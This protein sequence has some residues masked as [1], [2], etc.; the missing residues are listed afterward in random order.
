MSILFALIVGGLVFSF[1]SA[2]LDIYRL[3]CLAPKTAYEIWL[4]EVK[5]I[6]IV[7]SRST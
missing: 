4:E 5:K 1:V 2:V 6:S 3:N 7:A